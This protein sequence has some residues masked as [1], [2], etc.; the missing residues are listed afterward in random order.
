MKMTLEALNAIEKLTGK[1]LNLQ[2]GIN[3]LIATD[4]KSYAVRLKN[5]KKKEILNIMES[6]GVTANQVDDL[7]SQNISD[8]FCLKI[9]RWTEKLVKIDE[10]EAGKVSSSNHIH[11]RVTQRFVD[12]YNDKIIEA[13]AEQNRESLDNNQK[14]M[15]ELLSIF[16]IMPDFITIKRDGQF[17]ADLITPYNKDKESPIIWSEI[18]NT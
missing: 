9:T 6:A 13:A 1:S 16:N 5:E 15:G 18:P 10:L 3:A 2:W 14:I 17:Y 7:I 11:I 12:R 4:K 8:E